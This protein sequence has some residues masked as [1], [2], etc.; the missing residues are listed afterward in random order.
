MNKYPVI[1]KG[2]EYLVRWMQDDWDVSYLVV[3]EIKKVWK[4]KYPMKIYRVYECEIEKELNDRNIYKNKVEPYYYKEQIQF[5]FRLIELHNY[6]NALEEERV[7][8]LKEW[9]GIIEEVL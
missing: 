4:F 5:L 9:D 1:Y 3:Y 8:K 7:T 2:K 6:K